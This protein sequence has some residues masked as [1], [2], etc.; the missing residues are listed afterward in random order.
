MDRRNDSEMDVLMTPKDQFIKEDVDNLTVH[1]LRAK[2]KS[3]RLPVYG[4][5]RALCQRLLMSSTPESSRTSGSP[6]ELFDQVRIGNRENDSRRLSSTSKCKL[7]ELRQKCKDA[8][9]PSSG[10]KQELVDR[11]DSFYEEAILTDILLP[12]PRDDLSLSEWREPIQNQ[13]FFQPYAPSLFWNEP[14]RSKLVVKK[15]VDPFSIKTEEKLHSF[16]MSNLKEMSRTLG[17]KLSGKKNEVIKRIW[18]KIS[19]NSS[20]QI[21]KEQ[22]CTYEEPLPKRMKLDNSGYKATGSNSMR[23]KLRSNSGLRL[24]IEGSNSFE[25]INDRLEEPLSVR[26]FV[27]E[28][29]FTPTSFECVLCCQTDTFQSEEAPKVIISYKPQCSC[30]VFEQSGKICK[31]LLFIYLRILKVDT[32]DEILT[33]LVLEEE[34]LTEVLRKLKT[35]VKAVKNYKPSFKKSFGTRSTSQNSNS[36]EV[37]RENWADKVCGLCFEFLNSNNS[38]VWCRVKCGKNMHR[39]C[40]DRWCEYEKSEEKQCPYCFSVWPFIPKNTRF[41]NKM[42]SSRIE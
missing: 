34:E 30:K 21:Q 3:L 41:Q 14:Q 25:S 42:T 31:H 29:K 20:P 12:R 22:H 15:K 2:L 4:C 32:N 37:I 24:K 7:V 13:P 6:Y 5:K 27:F 16:N 38:M 33:K 1:Q 8:K 11:L 17:L 28:T 26:F 35:V 10:R 19:I 9:L 18:S 23:T 40:Y 39:S 36:V